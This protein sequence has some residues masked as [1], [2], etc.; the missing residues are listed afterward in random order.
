MF[1]LVGT[2]PFLRQCLFRGG[3]GHIN[4]QSSFDPRA[5]KVL[6]YTSRARSTT[7][8]GRRAARTRCGPSLNRKRN[9]RCKTTAQSIPPSLWV[10]VS[11][12]ITTIFPRLRISCKHS[13]LATEKWAFILQTRAPRLPSVTNL[14]FLMSL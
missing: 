1:G 2:F 10:K 11:F 6:R 12:P 3:A 9:S 8:H 5:I 14:D 4:L 13:S 7:S